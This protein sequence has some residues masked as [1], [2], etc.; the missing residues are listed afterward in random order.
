MF[1]LVYRHLA[2]YNNQTLVT[3]LLWQKL[4]VSLK[5]LVGNFILQE[6]RFFFFLFVKSSDQ[7]FDLSNDDMTV[8]DI[9]NFSWLF[10]FGNCFKAF[11]VEISL[12]PR[13]CYFLECFFSFCTLPVVLPRS[14]RSCRWGSHNISC[15]CCQNF[16]WSALAAKLLYQCRSRWIYLAI[17][18]VRNGRTMDQRGL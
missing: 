16:S 11:L 4:F 2:D 10:F 17:Y 12:L 13:N 7:K 18:N 14:K 8:K 3:P 15:C 5:V 9:K 1:S 6:F